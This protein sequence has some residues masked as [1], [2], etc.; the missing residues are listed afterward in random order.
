MD[1]YTTLFFFVSLV[2][3]L[4]GWF[5]FLEGVNVVSYGF[6][7]KGFIVFFVCVLCVLGRLKIRLGLFNLTCQMSRIVLHVY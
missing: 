7:A 3:L 2:G 1:K 6:M 5:L 4:F